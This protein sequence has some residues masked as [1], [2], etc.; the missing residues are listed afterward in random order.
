MTPVNK[1]DKNNFTHPTIKPI[2][3]IENFIKNSSTEDSV[4][5]DPFMGSGTTCLAAKRLN[6][7]YIGFEI[8]PK[9]YEI[10]KD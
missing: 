8:E 1:E 9:W 3:I 5:F 2:E 4:V 7:K 10:A 6:R